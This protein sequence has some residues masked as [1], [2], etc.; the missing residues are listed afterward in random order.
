[1]IHYTL[2]IGHSRVSPRNEVDPDILVGMKRFLNP[3][4]Y[5]LGKLHHALTGYRLVVPKT[6]SGL[7]ATLYEGQ[8]PLLTLGAVASEEDQVVV[9]P[10]LESLYLK[11][12]ELPV[13]RQADFAVSQCPQSLPWLAVVLIAPHLCSDW[14]GDFERCLAWAYLAEQQE[15]E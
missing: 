7:V 11:I 3:G 14:T 5:D 12:T 6:P 15:G 10:A 4:E 8:M 13:L 1:M 2:N 9:W